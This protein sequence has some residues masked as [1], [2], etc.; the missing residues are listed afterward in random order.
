MSGINSLNFGIN[1][2]GNYSYDYGVGSSGESI[3]T[4]AQ[5][6]IEES[7]GIDTPMEKATGKAECQTCKERKYV[8]GSDEMVSFKSPAKISP[9][10]AMSRVMAHEQEGQQ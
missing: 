1:G 9:E 4:D 2:Y 6:A 3:K 10:S 8:D 7:K 5:K